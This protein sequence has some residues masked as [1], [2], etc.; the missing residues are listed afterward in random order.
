MRYRDLDSGNLAR[1]EKLDLKE[2]QT[3]TGV[4]FS[5]LRLTLYKV[6]GGNMQTFE[7]AESEF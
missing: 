4:E 1:T 2:I 5:Q 7:T 6:A 3:V